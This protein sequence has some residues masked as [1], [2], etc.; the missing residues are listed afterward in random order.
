MAGLPSM[1]S[2]LSSKCTA[3]HNSRVLYTRVRLPRLVECGLVAGPA[4]LPDLRVLRGARAVF[5][6]VGFDGPA[7]DECGNFEDDAEGD[8]EA[9][10]AGANKGVG[11]A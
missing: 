1:K 10:G 2:P 8:A 5:P 11:V 6:A 3:A 9:T 7:E 4:G